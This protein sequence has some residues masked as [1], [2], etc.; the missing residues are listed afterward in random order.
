MR[1]LLTVLTA[2][3]VAPWGWCV[4]AVAQL[5][6]ENPNVVQ[7]FITPGPHMVNLIAVVLIF[8]TA[9]ISSLAWGLSKI[10]G[11]LRNDVG[12]ATAIRAEVVALEQRVAALE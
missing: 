1:V 10:I 3:A 9:L 12:N 11:A 7:E 2:A 4:P 5:P 6:A 8:G